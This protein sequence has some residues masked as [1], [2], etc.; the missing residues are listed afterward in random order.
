[1]SSP[2]LEPGSSALRVLVGVSGGIAAYKAVELVRLLKKEG[3]SVRCALTRA[4]GAFVTPLTLEVLSGH[5]VYQEEYLAGDGSGEELH[6][7]AAEWADVICVAPATAHTIARFANGLAD[8]FL[9]TTVLAFDGPLVLAP[10]MHSIMWRQESVSANVARLRER[11]VTLVGPAVG[12]LASGDVGIGRM[13]EPAEILATINGLQEPGPLAGRRVLIAAG[14]TREALDPVRFI[15]NRSSGKMGFALARAAVARGAAATLVAG[16]VS[17]PSPPGV[18]RVDVTS[19]E[20]M[21]AAVRIAAPQADLIVMAAAVADFKP[22]SVRTSKIKKSEG[23]LDSIEL[24]RTEDIL[25]GL[26]AIA[27]KAVIVGFAAETDDLLSNARSKR[28]GKDVDFIVANDVSR[29]D[30]GFEGD[31]NEVTVVGGDT[32]TRFERQSKSALAE[33]LIDHVSRALVDRE[34]QPA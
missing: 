10:A 3:H 11:G 30:I 21:A 31:H 1:M 12:P 33:R 16:P 19:A 13:V 23:G 28:V 20:E 4:A 5:R 14:P 29:A 9:S 24:E 6:I 26:R 18:E 8:D 34:R 15:S 2:R 17:L 22:T 7:T 27:P 32:E 25:A